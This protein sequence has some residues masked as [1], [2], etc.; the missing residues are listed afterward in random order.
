MW[1]G[2]GGESLILNTLATSYPMFTFLNFHQKNETA[3]IFTKE[4]PLKMNRT[5][6]K[7]RQKTEIAF[8]FIRKI[9]IKIFT[10]NFIWEIPLKIKNWNRLQFYK[11][12]P[13]KI[14]LPSILYENSFENY[15]NAPSILQKK[16]LEIFQEKK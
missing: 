12:I 1:E 7:V 5:K 15:F 9:P 8:N 2:M 10:F 16:S 14:F 3:F 4:I 11:R 6:K 13:F